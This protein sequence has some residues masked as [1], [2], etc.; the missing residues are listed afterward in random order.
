MFFFT[1]MNNNYIPK[2]LL[3]NNDTEFQM[4]L[5]L[6]RTPNR[7]LVEL[8]ALHVHSICIGLNCQGRTDR[9]SGGIYRLNLIM[10]NSGLVL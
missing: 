5:I 9:T 3:H 1:D 6:M 4:R 8:L 2:N 10:T 7:I